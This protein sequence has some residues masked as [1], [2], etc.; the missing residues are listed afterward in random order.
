MK[1]EVTDEELFQLIRHGNNAEA[2]EAFA[3]LQERKERLL[4]NSI[5]AAVVAI[6]ARNNS[7]GI[8]P[9]LRRVCPK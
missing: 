6:A 7:H 3:E 5:K 4:R 9:H 1:K 8:G 2:N